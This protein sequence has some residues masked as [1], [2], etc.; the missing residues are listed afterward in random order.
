[1]LEK[2]FKMSRGELM[3]ACSGSK[4]GVMTLDGKPE[5]AMECKCGMRYIV[6]WMKKQIVG[7]EEFNGH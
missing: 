1:M 6:D 7:M 5:I 4:K 3:S 2:I